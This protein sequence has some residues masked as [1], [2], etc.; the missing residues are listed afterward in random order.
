MEVKNKI[1]CLAGSMQYFDKM[2]EVAA[3]FSQQGYIVLMP[4]KDIREVIPEKSLRMYDDQQRIRINMADILY[5]VDPGGYIGKATTS[6]IEYAL[7]CGKSVQ[8]MEPLAMPY[9]ITLCGSRKFIAEFRKEYARLSLEGNIVH[10]PAIFSIED[11]RALSE[12]QHKILDRLHRM[13][14]LHSNEVY[15]IDP[16]GYIGEDTAKEIEW[17]TQNGIKIVF[18]EAPRATQKGDNDG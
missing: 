16:G 2:Q 13:K 1:I 14:M 12:E 11:P 3:D 9:T 5:V 18:L 17:A 6:E 10:M 7:K 15:I 8:Y 4:W